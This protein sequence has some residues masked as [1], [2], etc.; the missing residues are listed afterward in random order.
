MRRNLG[1]VDRV[2]RLAGAVVAAVCAV[3]APLT[4][5]VRL[6]AFAGTG[7][8]LLLTALAGTCLGYRLMGKSTCGIEQR[9]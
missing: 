8:Y 6:A 9:T 5:P 7:V 3:Q 1:S 2:L 4:L